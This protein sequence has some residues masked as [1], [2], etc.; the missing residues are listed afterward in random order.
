MSKGFL[1]SGLFFLLLISL[2]SC[3][4]S[5]FKLVDRDFKPKGKRL[6]VL[7]GL[8]NE[9]NVLA[10]QYMTEAMQ[11]YSWLQVMPQKQVGQL[12]PGYPFE[13]IGPYTRL[14]SRIDID[15]T[16]T[17][18]K[19]I[20][21]IQQRLGVDYLYVIWTY[22]S[23]RD[24]GNENMIERLHLVTQLFESRD[25]KE[26]GHGKFDVIPASVAC[27]LIPA[28]Q[29]EDKANAIKERMGDAA[30]EIAEKTGMLKNSVLNKE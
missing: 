27:C 22:A 14:F 15:Y 29:Y 28:P 26:A 17:D 16:N 23:T 8:D 25:G 13:I 9:A 2:V 5:N 18:V 12:L 19:A 1:Q 21:N 24:G 7:A 3:S 6:A 10:A 11:R 4:S 30:K 20:R